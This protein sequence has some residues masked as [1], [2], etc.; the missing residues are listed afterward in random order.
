MKKKYNMIYYIIYLKYLRTVL[1]AASGLFQ[2]ELQP[3]PD[4]WHGESGSPANEERERQTNVVPPQLC[5]HPASSNCLRVDRVRFYVRVNL[6][7]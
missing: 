2:R 7:T 1:V 6:G 4:T 3:I 5:P